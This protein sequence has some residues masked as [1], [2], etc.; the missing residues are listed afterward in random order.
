MANTSHRDVSPDIARSWL[1]VNATR[2]ETFDAAALAGD[3][4]ALQSDRAPR[5]LPRYSRV[6]HDPEPDSICVDAEAE[7]VFVEG[8]FL[9]LDAPVWRDM[10]DRFDCRI[11][12]DADDA[13]LQE[14]L[15]GRHRRGGKPP[16]HI[17][18]HFDRVDGP[19]IR[20]VRASRPY[21]DMAF[22]WDTAQ[23]WQPAPVD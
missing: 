5:R 1:L 11:Y 2:P 17:R 19:N 9:F 21:A 15:F 16:E 14:R 3:L 20:R 22:H 6:S 10:R 12:L 4:A 23:G 18:A 13:V 7:W 8:N